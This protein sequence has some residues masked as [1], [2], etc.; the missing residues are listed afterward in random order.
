MADREGTTLLKDGGFNHYRVA[1]ALLPNLT[2]TSLD[3]A[4]LQRFE[5]LFARVN[6]A[7]S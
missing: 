7:L 6:S 1:Q 5:N 2:S 3:T 4:D